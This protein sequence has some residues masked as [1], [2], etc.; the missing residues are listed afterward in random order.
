MRITWAVRR[1]GKH[2]RSPHH[3]LIS[4]VV[5]DRPLVGFSHRRCLKK[6]RR[7]VHAGAKIDQLSAG[8]VTPLMASVIG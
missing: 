7:A 5:S 1:S 2:T 8:G 3:H 4:S 6:I